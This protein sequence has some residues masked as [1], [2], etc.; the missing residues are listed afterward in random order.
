MIDDRNGSTQIIDKP[1]ANLPAPR[2]DERAAANAQ[3]VEPVRTRRISALAGSFRQ[4]VTSGS[5]ALAL[6]VVAGLATGTLVGMAW[7]KVPRATAESPSA[8][9]SVSELAPADPLSDSQNQQPGAEAF[10]GTGIRR[11]GLRSR[12][13]RGARAYRVAILR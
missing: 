8:N 13:S 2:F 9:H 12:S 10:A 6:V 4:A 11:S 1:Y 5:R 3:P 7:V